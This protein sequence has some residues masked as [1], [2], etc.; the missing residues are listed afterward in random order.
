MTVPCQRLDSAPFRFFFSLVRVRIQFHACYR[1]GA[2][3][4]RGS[5]GQ[6]PLEGE[7]E[8]EQLAVVRACGHGP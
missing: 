4:R 5:G 1:R 8:A 6:R 3:A 2:G 7:A